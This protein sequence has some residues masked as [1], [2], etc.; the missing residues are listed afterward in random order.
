[1]SYDR[2]S[3][4]DA[5]EIAVL[6]KYGSGTFDAYFDRYWTRGVEFAALARS[7]GVLALESRIDENALI[8]RD[9]FE[10]GIALVIDGTEPEFIDQIIDN[11]QIGMATD[12]EPRF[13]QDLLFVLVKQIIRGISEGMNPRMVNIICNSLYPSK[14]GPLK[15][16]AIIEKGGNVKWETIPEEELK[17]IKPVI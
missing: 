9:P 8:Q 5:E 10:V 13:Y 15:K 2:D 6:D 11:I 16:R 1:M 14:L 4:L 12:L 7:E 3:M 17:K